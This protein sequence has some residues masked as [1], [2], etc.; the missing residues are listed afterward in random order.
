MSAAAGRTPRPFQN[1]FLAVTEDQVMGTDAPTLEALI[2]GFTTEIEHMPDTTSKLQ[3]VAPFMRLVNQLHARERQLTTLPPPPAFVMPAA[4]P[5]ASLP[6]AGPRPAL[7]ALP[8]SPPA[9]KANAGFEALLRDIP[10]AAS[11][12]VEV[13]ESAHTEAAI[14]AG[15]VSN[16]P[17]GKILAELN[18][19][20]AAA[21]VEVDPARAE[22]VVELPP[23]RG[24]RGDYFS[25]VDQMVRFFSAGRQVRLSTLPPAHM[26]KVL[27]GVVGVVVTYLDRVATNAR[28][29]RLIEEAKTAAEKALATMFGEVDRIDRLTIRTGFYDPGKLRTPVG[30]ELAD[31]VGRD[32]DEEAAE[33]KKRKK[34]ARPPVDDEDDEDEVEDVAEV[35]GDEEPDG[36]PPPASF[37][38]PGRAAGAAAVDVVA[39]V[40]PQKAWSP[41]RRAA[42]DAFKASPAGQAK[43]RANMAKARA[44]RGCYNKDSEHDPRE[45][46]TA[47]ASDR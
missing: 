36:P 30:P 25:D 45:K 14:A 43:L 20:K 37:A 6:A 18:A 31:D 47:A 26:L 44:A 4:V 23:Y 34:G 21:A 13:L 24:V 15:A 35:D 38:V 1:R 10:V 12:A 8:P 9:A 46:R 32:A 33:E 7:P 5:A 19:A 27:A 3:F 42:W 16:K 2:D 39:A 41:E 29:A 28:S 11:P 17:R 22:A 40:K